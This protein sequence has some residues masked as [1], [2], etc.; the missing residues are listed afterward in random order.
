VS[1]VIGVKGLLDAAGREALGFR[2]TDYLKGPVGVTGTLTGRRG[3]LVAGDLALDLTPSTLSLDLL[4]ISKPMGFPASAHGLLGFGPHSTLRTAN[5]TIAGPSL[6]GAMT[7]VFDDNGK[8][9][10]LNA[11]AFKSGAANDFAFSLTRGPAGVD[12][13]VHGRSLDGT[14]I[15]RRGSS[16]AGT[17][18]APGKGTFDEPFHITAKLD[19]LALR[20]GVSISPFALDVSGTAERPAAMTLSGRIGKTGTLEG[21]IAPF[22]N[23]RRLRLQTNDFGTLAHG[24]FGFA[25]IKGGK[26]DLQATLHGPAAAPPTTVVDLANDYEG[27]VR[28]KDFRLLNQPFLA[29]LFSAGSLVGFGNLMQG[30]GIEVDDLKIPFSAKN[31]VLGILNARA[32]GP[33]IGVSAEGYVDRPKNEIALKGTLVP[34]FGINS[35]LGYI[36]LLGEL[37]VSKPGEGILGMVYSVEG[38]ADEPR[39]S[40]NPLSMVTPGFFRRI[41]EGKMPSVA[42]APSN[43][44]PAPAPSAVPPS[45]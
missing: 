13:D 28:L 40:I 19:R 18:D 3:Q 36:P 12:I 25:S 8:L 39:V 10:S 4:G 34:L 43:A 38:N 32:T 44:V 9:V 27:T 6:S 45:P 37:L 16:S 5:I 21:N 17:K 23:D 35:A 41:F 1:T 26:L 20:S 29:R 22:G 11:P 2:A 42:N 24:L 33:A 31:G 14:Q 7:V 15:A 30:G